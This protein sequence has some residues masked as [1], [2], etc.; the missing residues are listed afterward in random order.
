MI[1]SLPCRAHCRAHCRAS[2]STILVAEAPLGKRDRLQN[3]YGSIH[4]STCLTYHISYICIGYALHVASVKCLVVA[5]A[6]VF[7]AVHL[8]LL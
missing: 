3:G 4:T 5:V 8:V 7:V 1:L 6:L 2:S